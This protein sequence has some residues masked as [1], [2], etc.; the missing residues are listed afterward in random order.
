MLNPVILNESK[1]LKRSIW[2]VL[3]GATKAPLSGCEANKLS[4]MFCVCPEKQFWPDTAS[5][6]S[7]HLEG[8]LKPIVEICH[9]FDFSKHVTL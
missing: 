6:K 7:Q 5:F 4:G 3:C 1:V 2:Y 8:T 9:Y